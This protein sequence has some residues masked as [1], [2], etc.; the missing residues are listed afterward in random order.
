M[1]DIWE[2]KVLGLVPLYLECSRM[3][4]KIRL[5]IQK[6][7]P[8]WKVRHPWGRV[9]PAAQV[10]VW[11]GSQGQGRTSQEEQPLVSSRSNSHNFATELERR[12]TM[13]TWWE[14]EKGS[15]VTNGQKRLQNWSSFEKTINC[16]WSWMKNF[17][18]SRGTN[19]IVN[20]NH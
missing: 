17:T 2:T 16:A 7:V 6:S 12:N 3:S 4:R 10:E 8:S 11:Q 20:K 13:D 14:S 15:H 18:I 5:W 19:K 1:Q 9:A